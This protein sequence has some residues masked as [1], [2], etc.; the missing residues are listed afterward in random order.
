MSEPLDRP[1]ELEGATYKL[2]WPDSNHAIYITRYTVI[3]DLLKTD[4]QAQVVNLGDAPKGP[5]C[6]ACGEFGMHMVEGCM[7]CGSCG[8]SK[9]SG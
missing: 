4:P 6:P 5:A 1:T 7:T 3:E 9:C 2:K 8:H